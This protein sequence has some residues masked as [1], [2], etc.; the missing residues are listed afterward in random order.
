MKV[1][2]LQDIPSV[3]RKYDIKDVADG[4][5]RNFL[6]PRK[7]GVPAT[8][9]EIGQLKTTLAAREGNKNLQED[10]LLKNIA[11]LDGETVT[12]SAKANEK[13]HLFAKIDQEKI[14][15]AIKQQ[16]NFEIPIEYITLE[17]PIK[18]VGEYQMSVKFK[19]LNPQFKIIISAGE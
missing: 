14:A 7:L 12:L 16:K 6:M 8:A 2:L 5:A 1:I 3:G 15:E 17:A 18:E 19:N 11:A 9:K 13:G 4:Y 10:L